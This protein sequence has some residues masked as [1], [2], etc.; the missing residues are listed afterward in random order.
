MYHHAAGQSDE[1]QKRDIMSTFLSRHR[2]VERAVE[3]W[4]AS[5]RVE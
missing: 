4:R 3:Q 5:R 2:E 1:P